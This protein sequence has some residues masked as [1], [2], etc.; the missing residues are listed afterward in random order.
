MNQEQQIQASLE[1]MFD[2]AKEQSKNTL[3][4]DG[5]KVDNAYIV[6]FYESAFSF[7]LKDMNLTKDQ[8]DLL[9]RRC[10]MK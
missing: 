1:S 3:F 8:M 10:E 9:I 7:M 6:G 2:F 4:N 5:N